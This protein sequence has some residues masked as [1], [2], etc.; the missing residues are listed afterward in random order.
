[1]K[2][3]RTAVFTF[4]FFSLLMTFISCSNMLTTP[5]KD[6]RD[7]RS[8]KQT[9]DVLVFKIDSDNIG[10]LEPSGELTYKVGS[11]NQISFVES[12]EYQFIKWQ[13]VNEVTG[14]LVQ[15]VIRIED[16]EKAETKITILKSAENI[17][18]KP[19]CKLRP[20]VETAMPLLQT[21]G[22]YCDSVI[23]VTFNSQISEKSIYYLPEEITSL[24]YDTLLRNEKG[25]YGYVINDNIHYKNIS[26]T[27]AT[28]EN[29]LAFY[30]PPEI[31]NNTI[32]KLSPVAEKRLVKNEGSLLDIDVFI[33]P[34]F[35]DV[36]GVSIGGEGI[37]WRYRVN[38][39]TDTTPP[40]FEKFV[41]TDRPEKLISSFNGD[42]IIPGSAFNRQNHIKDTLYY[43]CI[44]SDNSGCLNCLKVESKR[45]ET[46]SGIP[47]N[48]DSIVQLLTDV[49]Q[50]EIKLENEDGVI[51]LTFTLYDMSGNASEKVMQYTV[52][53]DTQVNAST[54]RIYSKHSFDLDDV[55]TVSDLDTAAKTIS[56][57]D[58]SDDLWQKNNITA[59]SDLKYYLCWG[60]KPG[61]YINQ[62]LCSKS[63]NYKDGVWTAQISS[64]SPNKEVYIRVIIEDELGNQ[65]YADAVI[66]AA[67]DS[68]TYQKLSDAGEYTYIDSNTG[69]E[70]T[71]PYP[72]HYRI[73]YSNTNFVSNNYTKIGY[74]YYSY[75]GSS[76]LKTQ[77]FLNLSSDEYSQTADM[78]QLQY[79]DIYVD[80]ISKCRF[81]FQMAYC[82]NSVKENNEDYKTYLSSLFK[83][84][85][86]E[87]GNG[88]L[89][90]KIESYNP[91]F[92]NIY[93][94]N[95]TKA[96][97]QEAEKLLTNF[98]LW[99]N[100]FG[101]ES[102]K[103]SKSVLY[104]SVL[105]FKVSESQTLTAP[106]VTSISITKGSVNSGVNNATVNFASTAPYG[107]VYNFLW[108]STEDTITNYET[109]ESFN[110]DSGI[111]KLYYRTVAIDSKT[112]ESKTSDVKLYDLS[113]CAYDTT[114]PVV[115][116]LKKVEKSQ[117]SDSFSASEYYPVITCEICYD[118]YK[119]VDG[120]SEYTLYVVPEKER[121]M[122]FDKLSEDE[123]IESPHIVQKFVP[124]VSEKEKTFVW[125]KI[126]GLC[127]KGRCFYV[128]YVED[129]A[130]NYSYTPIKVSK[131]LLNE[132]IGVSVLPYDNARMNVSFEID[133]NNA[134][135]DYVFEYFMMDKN[136]SDS[137]ANRIESVS[138]GY[139]EN[140]V[141]PVKKDSFYYVYAKAKY[142]DMSGNKSYERYSSPVYFYTGSEEDTSC[143]LKELNDGTNGAQVYCDRPC[144][145]MTYWSSENYGNDIC[146]WEAYGV[147]E[148]PMFI[149]S[150]NSET[151][152]FED[153]LKYYTVDSKAIPQ[154]QFFV[155]IAHFADG[156]SLMSKSVNIN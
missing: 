45:I 149:S 78:E 118:K 111:T 14:K 96:N 3:N 66:P 126:E 155:I 35:E 69:K 10:F 63:K 154:G 12:P 156:T 148:N 128:M 143:E 6:D 32:L 125:N 39:K 109:S 99:E 82:N 48:E 130:G 67:P 54:C 153:T 114:P 104:S 147:H 65:G 116:N 81:Y 31:E 28:D 34:D 144:L 113:N 53:K 146:K 86:T 151:G 121:G 18:L 46:A 107:V 123:I 4:I 62:L 30:N 88:T 20:I 90:R 152:L 13:V 129:A 74:L 7:M 145:V 43:S 61:E 55:Y 105:E 132:R 25:V 140:A 57:C 38:S 47:V 52:A 103:Y 40:L 73:F 8:S 79:A 16:P 22:V 89:L 87:K 37:Q 70:K 100:Y 56:W 58:V 138:K 102:E 150:T 23:L 108:G 24:E 76:E 98:Y 80:D 49:Q 139:T 68:F 72:A 11:T 142:K 101:V 95:K 106:S 131:I 93:L 33:S 59:A 75:E 112:S 42:F 94:L 83:N 71:I 1:M 17:I 19:L 60:Y 27:S 117:A 84:I 85:K 92:R 137:F 110:I 36:D 77:A 64:F 119:V 5:I 50:G 21:E 97:T 133:T 124:P 26:I 9:S 135:S 134:C 51:E 2:R 115:E 127:N 136:E 44:C 15:D 41:L 29:L 141:V 91:E 120:K 122:T